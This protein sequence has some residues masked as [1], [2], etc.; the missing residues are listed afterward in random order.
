LFTLVGIMGKVDWESEGKA[1]AYFIKAAVL[2]VIAAAIC[3]L[4][5]AVIGGVFGFISF[6]LGALVI[7]LGA[8]VFGAAIQAVN[9]GL[10]Y[11]SEF[12][13]QRKR[14]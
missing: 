3:G 12:A 6:R 11:R 8:M 4:G 7:V 9:G 14:R 1:A 10:Y 13:R 2:A 5:F